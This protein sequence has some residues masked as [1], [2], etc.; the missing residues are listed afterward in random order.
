MPRKISKDRPNDYIKLER[1]SSLA[2]RFSKQEGRSD[3][4]LNWFG[5]EILQMIHDYFV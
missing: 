3:V 2:I 5:N 1:F 4:H